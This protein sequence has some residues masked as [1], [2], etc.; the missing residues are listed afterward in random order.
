MADVSA[1]LKRKGKKVAVSISLLGSFRRH[2]PEVLLAAQFFQESG[3]EVL[4]PSISSVLDTSVEFVRFA[5]DASDATDH[6]IQL[7]TLRSILSS[8]LVY[9]VA[10]GG[11]IGRTTCYEIGRVHERGIPT[12]FSEYPKDL[13]IVVRPESVVKPS[14]L[15]KEIEELGRVPVVSDE[16]V[17]PE[18]LHLERVLKELSGTRPA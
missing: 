11:Y 4:S 3:M 13:P 17:P 16:G 9:V 10:P 6:E 2:Y 15:A 18:I 12:F 5:S 7:R 1:N 14:S 8:D